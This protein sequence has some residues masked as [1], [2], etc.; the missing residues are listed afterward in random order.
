MTDHRARWR[1]GAR[2]GLIAA[3]IGILTLL[4]AGALSGRGLSVLADAGMAGLPAT[5][6]AATGIPAAL[7]YLLIHT[8]LYMLA[9]VVAL[10]LA[11]LADRVP[12]LV[13][14]LVLAIIII[15]FGFLVFTTEAR[16]VDGSTR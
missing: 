2:V 6:Q 11:G 9:G 13:A 16:Q 10:A 4:L 3:I 15:E 8:L 7:S 1:D 14:G 5:I 12:P